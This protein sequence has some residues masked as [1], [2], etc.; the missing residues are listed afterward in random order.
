MDLSSNEPVRDNII[1]IPCTDLNFVALCWVHETSKGHGSPLQTRVGTLI[2][3]G[4]LLFSIV[5]ILSR[6][7]AMALINLEDPARVDSGPVQVI[8]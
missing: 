1:G 8:I 5:A 6:K 7:Q 2:G 3:R 4:S